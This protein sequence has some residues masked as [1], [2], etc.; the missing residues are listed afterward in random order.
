M[1]FAVQGPSIAEDGRNAGVDGCGDNFD[2]GELD[3]EIAHVITA[4]NV[5]FDSG[6]FGDSL[7]VLIHQVS[8]PYRGNGTAYSEWNIG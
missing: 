7:V 2:A 6:L 8:R 5:D 3:G 4:F 1:G